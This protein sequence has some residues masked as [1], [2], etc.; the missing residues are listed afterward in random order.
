M[1]VDDRQP[2]SD[3]C[4]DTSSSTAAAAVTSSL[5]TDDVTSDGGHVTTTGRS[6]KSHSVQI[7]EPP[8]TDTCHSQPATSTSQTKVVT[9]EKQGPLRRAIPSMPLPLAVIAC[10]LNIILP[11]TGNGLSNYYYS[12]SV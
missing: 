1:S 9:K 11:G 3:R 6:S 12:V 7:R 2:T 4:A 5:L 10:I 8:V